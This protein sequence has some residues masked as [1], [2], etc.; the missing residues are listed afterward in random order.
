MMNESP[1]QDDAVIRRL[2]KESE[3]DETPELLE[4][5]RQLRSFT[6]SPAVVPTGEL[7]VLLAETVRPRPRSSRHRVPI[8]GRG[9]DG[10]CC[11]RT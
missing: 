7:A 11:R 10:G 4:G 8:H 3:I 5:L 9:P 6:G 1:D 2:L